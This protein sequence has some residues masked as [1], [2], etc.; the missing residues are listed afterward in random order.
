MDNDKKSEQ[1][2][3]S[4]A[5]TNENYNI[6]KGIICILIAGMGFSLMTAFVRLSGS[7]PTFEKAFFRHGLE[8]QVR[9]ERE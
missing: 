7:L 8:D 5:V 9:K 6:K 1:S 4:A 2:K 3:S